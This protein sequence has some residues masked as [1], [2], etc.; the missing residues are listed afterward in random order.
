MA[1][2]N[3]TPVNRG[4]A[5]QRPREPASVAGVLTAP[6]SAGGPGTG[7][8]DDALGLVEQIGV[9]VPDGD[10]V[11]VDKAAQAG[12]GWRRCITRTRSSRR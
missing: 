1:D 12:T 9:P 10:T 11:K 8:L 6:P 5:P 7:L 3:A 4:E 2:Y